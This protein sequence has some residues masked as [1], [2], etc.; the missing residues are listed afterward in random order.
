MNNDEA[1]PFVESG[2]Q[3]WISTIEEQNESRNAKAAPTG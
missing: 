3:F 1:L 2:H